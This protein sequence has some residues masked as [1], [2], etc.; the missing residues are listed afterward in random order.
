[1]HL[2]VHLLSGRA[3]APLNELPH[4]HSIP[5]CIPANVWPALMQRVTQSPW[6]MLEVEA[7]FVVNILAPDGSAKHP[8]YCHPLGKFGAA[9]CSTLWS[10][11]ARSSE[12]RWAVPWW[13]E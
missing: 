12:S 13:E 11:T 10:G 2:E 5:Y 3:T 1:M 9:R 4:Q 8:M 6:V 7:T